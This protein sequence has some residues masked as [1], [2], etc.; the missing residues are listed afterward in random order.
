MVSLSR[1]VKISS[2]FELSFKNKLPGSQ[3]SRNFKNRV[4]SSNT[5]N[6]ISNLMQEPQKT[7]KIPKIDAIF[8]AGICS[9]MPFVLPALFVSV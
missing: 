3:L 1:N 7:P 6:K 2:L 8:V 4:Y 9:V 5:N